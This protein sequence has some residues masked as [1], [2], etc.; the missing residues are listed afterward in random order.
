[1]D[2]VKIKN[3][4]IQYNVKEM[5]VLTMNIKTGETAIIQKLLARMQKNLC[6]TGR[7]F[8]LSNRYFQ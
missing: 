7:N 8:V 2:L 6:L 5:P 4:D 1:M 3:N